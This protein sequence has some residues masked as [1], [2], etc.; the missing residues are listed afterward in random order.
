[1]KKYG[2]KKGFTLIA[3]MRI[4]AIIGILP[5]IATPNFISYRN[6]A[7]RSVTESDARN[8]AAAVSDCFSVP[9]H[10]GVP[11][12]QASIEAKNA[13]LMNALSPQY[14]T[15]VNDVP[16]IEKLQRIILEKVYSEYNLM[17]SLWY[18]N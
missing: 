6:K 7:H 10:A 1:M 15:E 18:R 16:Q 17:R 4:V 8:I 12:L 5:V 9:R 11:A 3:V 13:N 2:N 14:G